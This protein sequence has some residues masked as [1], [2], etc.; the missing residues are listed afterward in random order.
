M[1]TTQQL[2]D[3]KLLQKE[4][5]AFDQVELKLNWEMLRDRGNNQMDFLHYENNKLVAFLA[6]YPFG[7]TVEVCGMVKPDERRKGYFRHLLMQGVAASRHLGYNKM[8]LNAPAGSDSA[9]AFLQKSGAEYALSEHQMVWQIRRVE[10]VEGI[11]LRPALPSDFDLRVHLSVTAFG[12]DEVDALTMES[13][14]NS[15][16]DSEI[17]MIVVDKKTVGKIRISQEDGQAWIYGF[18]ILPE[19]QG[20]GIGRKVLRRVIKEQAAAG[21]S[22]HLEVQTQNDHALGLYQSVGFQAVHTQDYY[23]HPL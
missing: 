22:I 23:T 2:Q 7:S 18:S 21:Y 6:L 5:E 17:F 10:E 12:L 3:I 13:H 14:V 9:K 1:L 16:L 20:K 19:H 15:C 4:C 8:L 11:M